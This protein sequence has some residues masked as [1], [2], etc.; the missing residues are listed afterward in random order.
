M[1]PARAKVDM[2]S[3][4]KYFDELAVTMA[5]VAPENVYNY[6]KINVSN[7]PELKTIIC[8]RGLKWV[9]RKMQHSKSSVSIMFCGNA[10]GEYLP[11]MVVYKA[12]KV[13]TKWTRGGPRGS[14]Y[15]CTKSGWFDSRCFEQWFREIFLPHASAKDGKKVILGDN[16]SS[17]FTPKVIQAAVGNNIEIVCLIPNSAHILKPLDVAV[18]RPVKVEWRKIMEAWW[19][20][21]HIMSSQVRFLSACYEIKFSGRYR[22]LAYVILKC[23]RPSHP[24]WGR[25][26]GESRRRG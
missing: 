12:Q 18:F 10:V 15:D 2:S 24:D 3:V 9:K 6:D 17:H 8:R 25:R 7:N 5:D 4:N 22:G 20:E 23:D 14:I 21:S 13:Y 26:C 19:N 11:L 16:L 1:K